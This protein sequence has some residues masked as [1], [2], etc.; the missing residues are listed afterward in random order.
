MSCSSTAGGRSA[1]A[2]PI[3]AELHRTLMLGADTDLVARLL[4]QPLWYRDALCREY[5]DLD[6][7]P[8]NDTQNVDP[9]RAICARCAVRRECLTAA[10]DDGSHGIWG[11]TTYKERATA[12]ARGITADELLGWLPTRQLD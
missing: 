4:Q 8:S 12:R 10:L 2:R 3:V 11:A 6:W 9:Q 7:M 1:Y 5:P